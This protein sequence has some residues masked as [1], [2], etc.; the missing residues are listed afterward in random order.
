[1]PVLRLV[2]PGRND[3]DESGETRASAACEELHEVVRTVGFGDL[4]AIIGE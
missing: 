1:M 4:V 3:N 2:C